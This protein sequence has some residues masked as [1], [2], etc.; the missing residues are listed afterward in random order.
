VAPAHWF[1]FEV[2]GSATVGAG[3]SPVAARPLRLSPNPF[4]PRTSVSFELPRSA[5]VSLAVYAASGRLVTRLVEGEG[6]AAGAHT[7]TWD[8]R[9][10]DGQ[11]VAAGVYLFR[12]ETGERIEL[13]RGVLVR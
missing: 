6:L 5:T 11:R 13:R 10:H 7:F 9:A 4:R 3:S 1:S 8:G 2:E 12:L